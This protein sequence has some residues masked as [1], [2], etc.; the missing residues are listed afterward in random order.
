MLQT[1]SPLYVLPEAPQVYPLGHA[2]PQPPQ[3]FGSVARLAHVLPQSVSPV[4]HVQVPPTQ[5]WV[6]PHVTPP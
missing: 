4:G 5:D 6:A 1:A 3:L 2:T